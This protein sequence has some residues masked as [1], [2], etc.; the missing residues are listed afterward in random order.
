M[1]A[2]GGDGSAV[3]ELGLAGG[4][5]GWA[6]AAFS[7]AWRGGSASRPLLAMPLVLLRAGIVAK[8]VQ[9]WAP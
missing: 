9:L 3:T 7:R 2:P 5:V 4:G 8:D 6:D 1:P